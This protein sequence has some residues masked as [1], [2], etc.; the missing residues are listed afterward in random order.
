MTNEGCRK[1]T[2][3][4]QELST[5]VLFC[6]LSCFLCCSVSGGP[7]A[8]DLAEEITLSFPYRLSVSVSLSTLELVRGVLFVICCS[9]YAAV[10]AASLPALVVVAF[11]CGVVVPVVVVTVVAADAVVACAFL[12]CVVAESV[13][14]VVL[15]AVACAVPLSPVAT[16]ESVPSLPLTTSGRDV[17]IIF[18]F[19]A[20]TVVL[21][22]VVTGACAFVVITSAV[23]TASVIVGQRSC[24]CCRLF[25][26]HC[27]LKARNLFSC[28]AIA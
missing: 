10:A 28:L 3:C 19:V 1:S 18:A 2:P 13:V 15:L 5:C 17:A 26:C 11:V 20:F 27:A 9:M 21:V 12:V 6:S 16:F 25:A 22:A 8:R 14:V 24:C 23:I 4:K 7:L